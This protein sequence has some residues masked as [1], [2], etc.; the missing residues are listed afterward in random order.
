MHD[1]TWADRDEPR[2]QR[3]TAQRIFE[4]LRD[5]HGFAGA[6]K[7]AKDQFRVRRQ[8]TWKVRSAAGERRLSF[9]A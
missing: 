5:E 7:I 2:K 8:S 3:H 9:S 1:L 6:Y 4:R